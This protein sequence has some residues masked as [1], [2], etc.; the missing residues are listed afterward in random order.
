MALKNDIMFALKEIQKFGRNL[1]DLND[2]IT[3]VAAHLSD[4]SK[5]KII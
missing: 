5:Q 4:I 3:V 1:I 2:L